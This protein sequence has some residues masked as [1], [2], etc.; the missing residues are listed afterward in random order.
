MAQAT[1]TLIFLDVR[2]Q[3][4]STLVATGVNLR[5]VTVLRS[6]ELLPL[7]LVK[8]TV[9]PSATTFSMAAEEDAI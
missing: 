4:V 3:V 6:D 5:I 9:A 2:V 8:L 7:I 1:A